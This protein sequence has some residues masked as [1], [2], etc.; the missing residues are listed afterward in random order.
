M[1]GRSV[2]FFLQY[3]WF[4]SYVGEYPPKQQGLNP[5]L[6]LYDNVFNSLRIT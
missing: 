2:S 3:K 1:T 4:P 5:T 6:L